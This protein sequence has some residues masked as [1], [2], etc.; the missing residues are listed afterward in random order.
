MDSLYVKTSSGLERLDLGSSG[1]GAGVSRKV[2]SSALRDA[3]LAAGAAFGVPTYTVGS[4]SL[5]VFLDGLLC[6]K[7]RE[8][9]EASATTV[10]FTSVIDADTQIVAVVT[11]GGT[12][13]AR[14]VQVD[15]SRS[16]AITAGASYAVPTHTFGGRHLS[17]LLDGL[18]A[19]EG[20]NFE[21]AGAT[22]IRFLSAI[23][24]TTQIVVVVEG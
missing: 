13:A 9:T 20:V 16:S 8:Y 23:P 5:Q 14:A 21:D 18:A 3:D 15:E 12:G 22:S 17:V 4:N 1:G 24:Q 7:G 11:E 10:T 6:V 19:L 2:F